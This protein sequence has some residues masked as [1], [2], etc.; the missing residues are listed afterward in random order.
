MVAEETR[1]LILQNIPTGT[2]VVQVAASVFLTQPHGATYFESLQVRSY[3]AN[4]FRVGDQT[5]LPDPVASMGFRQHEA[6]QRFSF[7]AKRTEPEPGLGFNR[8]AFE[9]FDSLF[10]VNT[11]SLL[12]VMSDRYAMHN[13]NYEDDP[14]DRALYVNYILDAVFDQR[15]LED[16]VHGYRLWQSPLLLSAT[17]KDQE[18]RVV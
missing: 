18:I 15:I 7:Y 16:R 6:R 1:P 5:F 3:Q 9:D 4:P 11:A 10:F 14:D 13:H 2:R 8:V 17:V 12:A